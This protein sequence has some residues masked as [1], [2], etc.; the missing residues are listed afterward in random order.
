MSKRN[1]KVQMEVRQCFLKYQLTMCTLLCHPH[2]NRYN[3]SPFIAISAMNLFKGRHDNMST[4]PK[5]GKKT[6]N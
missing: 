1:T 4:H 3:K 6:K 2:A 5:G